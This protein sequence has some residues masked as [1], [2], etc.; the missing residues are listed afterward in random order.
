[1]IM[2]RTCLKTPA[3]KHISDLE[4][5]I[6]ECNKNCFEIMMF[7]LNIEVTE[8]SQITSNLCTNCYR[9][10]ISFYKF[11]DL[12]LKNDLY[13]KSLDSVVQLEDQKLS[14]YVDENGIKHENLLDSDDFGPILLGDYDTEFKVEIN[15]KCNNSE[16][17]GETDFKDNNS[18][19]DEEKD[20]IRDENI[21]HNGKVDENHKSVEQKVKLKN[22]VKDIKENALKKLGRRKKDKS[23]K[24]EK[25]K[26]Q[27]Q[28]CEECGKSFLNL[29]E[30][31]LQHQPKEKR[32]KLECK[33]CPKSFF[34]IGGRRKHYLVTHLGFKE[35][36]DI[37]GKE[38]TGLKHHQKLVHNPSALPY[39]CVQC[40]RRF[41]GQS[42]LDAH[43]VT[44]TKDLPFECDV[45]QKRF[46]SKNSVS[47]HISQV[48]EKIRTHQ[49]QFCS[50]AFFKIER[51]RAHVRSHTNERPH[52][53]EECGKAFSTAHYL[54][55]HALI[56]GAKHFQCQHCSMSFAKRGNLATHMVKHTKEKRYPCAFCGARFGRSDHRNRHQLTAHKKQRA[57]D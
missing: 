6:K 55:E 39:G 32:Q 45:C 20:F 38:V 4:N 53:C 51:L 16:E 14:V 37:C 40:E 28:V 33:A 31:A 57:A 21:S 47:R 56:H 10:I 7:C 42:A 19:D 30:H 12:S 36:C 43:M 34:S 46:G 11:K 9:K 17:D 15:V 29:K 35:K 54:K 27:R 1:M 8:D 50:K 23:Q 3:E 18:Y 26:P 49:C 44:H 24:K 2:C 52:K 13:L 48:H 22:I 41:V 25:W 5:G